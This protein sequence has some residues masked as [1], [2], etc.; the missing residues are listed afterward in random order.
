MRK[1]MGVVCGKREGE[2]KLTSITRI[3]SFSSLYISP[4]TLAS[5]GVRPILLQI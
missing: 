5:S 4:K 3:R 2:I 1:E